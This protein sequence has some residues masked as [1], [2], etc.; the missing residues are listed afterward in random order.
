MENFL[1]NRIRGK[2]VLHCNHCTAIVRYDV[3]VI[4]NTEREHNTKTDLHKNIQGTDSVV[5]DG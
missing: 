5:V 4:D 1:E 2:R 3:S